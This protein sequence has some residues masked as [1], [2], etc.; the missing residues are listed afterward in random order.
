MIKLHFYRIYP[1][2]KCSHDVFLWF[3]TGLDGV[4]LL[5]DISNGNMVSQMKDHTDTVYSLCFSRCGSVLA[6]GTYFS[7]Y[8]GK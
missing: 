7:D 3:H 6:S 4:I 1:I 2:V 5:W 8:P